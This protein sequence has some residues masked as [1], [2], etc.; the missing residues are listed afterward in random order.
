MNGEEEAQRRQDVSS[1]RS[2]FIIQKG[3]K[4]GKDNEDAEQR[5]REHLKGEV[6]F[7]PVS[8][9]RPQRP[10]SLQSILNSTDCR[11]DGLELAARRGVKRVGYRSPL[12]P[13]D[14]RARS[15]SALPSGLFPFNNFQGMCL[16]LPTVSL[17]DKANAAVLTRSCFVHFR[18]CRPSS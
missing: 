1:S 3:P 8:G 9:S 4:R 12:L 18:S 15:S 17:V 6:I 13:L 10:G 14:S 16:L 2:L 11:R 7:W 5:W